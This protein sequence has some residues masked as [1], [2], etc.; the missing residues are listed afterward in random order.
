MK[1]KS[2]RVYH[3]KITLKGINP[4]VWRT[5]QVPE[6]YTFWDLHVAVQDA[7]G[8][9][10]CHLHDFAVHNPQAQTKERIGIPDDDAEFDLDILPGWDHNISDY[11]STKNSTATYVYDYGDNWE[12]AV[13]FEKIVP[14]DKE[15]KYPRC[16]AGERACPPENCAGIYGYQQFLEAIMD[17]G[18]KSHEDF[19]QWAGADVEPERFSPNEVH[20]DD[21]RKR[22]KRAFGTSTR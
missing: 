7:M 9:Q 1:K 6:T 3:F 11:F 8:W 10:D 19:L 20:F 21:P 14:R 16:I 18:H 13:K 5:I 22:W 17:P 2:E 4:P 12:H 15:K